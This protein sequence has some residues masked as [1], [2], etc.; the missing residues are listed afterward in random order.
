MN[1]L[2]TLYYEDGRI[3]KGTYVNDLKH[4]PGACFWPN[5]QK[6]EGYWDKGK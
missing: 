6:V 1:G 3:F 4:G 5:G 2:G